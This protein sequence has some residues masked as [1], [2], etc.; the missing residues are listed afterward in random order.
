MFAAL[1]QEGKGPETA[2]IITS[3]HT[4]PR[5]LPRRPRVALRGDAGRAAAH[6]TRPQLVGRAPFV[7]SQ[8]PSSPC[9]LVHKPRTGPSRGLGIKTESMR[10][11]VPE[12]GSW[13]ASLNHSYGLQG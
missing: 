5:A 8:P 3:S 13:R 12:G 6:G 1:G 10:F 9:L 7:R 11:L 2:S 4:S